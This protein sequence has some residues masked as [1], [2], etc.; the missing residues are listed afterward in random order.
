VVYLLVKIKT[1]QNSSSSLSTPEVG[2]CYNYSEAEFDSISPLT[3]PVDCNSSHNAE[4]YFVGYWVGSDNLLKMPKS[5]I[6]AQVEKFC[7][8]WNLPEDTTLNYWFY[9][10][11]TESEWGLHNRWVRCDAGWKINNSDE[12]KSMAFGTWKGIKSVD[13]NS[14]ETFV[15]NGNSCFNDSIYDSKISNYTSGWGRNQMLAF[16]LDVIDAN[17]NE[18]TVGE[19]S[20]LAYR[21]FSAKTQSGGLTKNE[22]DISY[23]PGFG[24]YNGLNGFFS[25]PNIAYLVKEGMKC[26]ASS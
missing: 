17:G 14:T 18:L 22:I 19:F 15:P 11:P 16:G 25:D 2:A 24:L 5:E 3:E 1:Q 4:T 8:P 7:V 21:V 12:S 10:L 26:S 9:F 23:Q 13:A 20:E 6:S